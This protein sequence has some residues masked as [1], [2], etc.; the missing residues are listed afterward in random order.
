[1]DCKVSDTE[2]R[3][4]VEILP[5]VFKLVILSVLD[6]FDLPCH[7]EFRDRDSRLVVHPTQH[8]AELVRLSGGGGLDLYRRGSAES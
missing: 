1:M 6:N 8:D 7:R 4:E 3:L 2:L 5:D